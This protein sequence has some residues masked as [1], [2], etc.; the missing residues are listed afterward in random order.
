M[1]N[2]KQIM[3]G[4]LSVIVCIMAVGYA[5]LSQQLTVN[6]TAHI[7]STWDVRITNITAQANTVT[8]GAA[9]TAD[10]PYVEGTN[11]DG[12]RVVNTATANFDAALMNPGDSVVY[13][14]TV[15]NYGT[16]PAALASFTEVYKNASNT[17]IDNSAD[18]AI[19]YTI[20]GISA[21]ST[22]GYTELAARQDASTPTTIT[23]T[24]TATYRST[25]TAQPTADQLKKTLTLTLNFQ[26][27]M[28]PGTAA[29]L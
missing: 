2:R 11:D 13:T 27:D 9:G 3:I 5:Y 26:Q 22:N 1:E 18:D 25:V 4:V 15:A 19:V 14:V 17:T 21:D 12:T 10:Q 29:T 16:L 6:G 7:D 24:V 8:G 23:F 20:S 28:T